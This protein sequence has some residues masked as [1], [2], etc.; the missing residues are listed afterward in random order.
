LLL[1]VGGRRLTV[2]VKA[3]IV[4]GIVVNLFGAVTFDRWG[5]KYYRI[6]RTQ[7]PNPYEVIV[8]H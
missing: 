4:A 5:W 1:A 7:K 8:A 2:P 3:V 6:D